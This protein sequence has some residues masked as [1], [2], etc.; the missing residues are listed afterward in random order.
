MLFKRSPL[1]LSI[2]L[3]PLTAHAFTD[4]APITRVTPEYE[5][6]RVPQEDCRFEHGESRRQQGDTN[7]TGAVVGAGV[8]AAIGNRFGKGA[9]RALS[10]AAG[11]IGGAA[12]GDHLQNDTTRDHQDCK[13]Y[14][15]VEQH[16]RG[17]RVEYSYAGRPYTAVLPEAPRGDE[18]PVHVEV[19]PELR[20]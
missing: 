7:W 5:E 3:L 10:T 18:L 9:G 11:M 16:V 15:R 12:L 1:L 20:R 13:R 14:E 8:G 4:Y 17:Y 19:S 6:T 2:I